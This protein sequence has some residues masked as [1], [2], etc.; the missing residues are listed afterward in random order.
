MLLIFQA[1]ILNY[2]YIGHAG[3]A[4]GKYGW[5]IT[6]ISLRLWYPMYVNVILTSIVLK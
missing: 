6:V 5:Y 4:M 2:T 1:N 3:Y